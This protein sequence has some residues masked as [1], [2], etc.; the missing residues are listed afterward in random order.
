VFAAISVCR[1]S[2]SMPFSSVYCSKYRIFTRLTKKVAAGNVFLRFA[3]TR[4]I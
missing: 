4:H 1:E 3:D 2:G